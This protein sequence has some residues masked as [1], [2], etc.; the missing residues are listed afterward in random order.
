VSENL[1][2]YLKVIVEDNGPGIPDD[3]KSRLSNRFQRGQTKATGKGL[4][5][6]LVKT[7]VDSY[8]GRIWV[9]DR[10]PGDYT[11]GARFILVLPAA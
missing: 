10:V 11:Q 6:F 7:L 1:K 2:A 3:L 5:L 9:E 4:G 8:G